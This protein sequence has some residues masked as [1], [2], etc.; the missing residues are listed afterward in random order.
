MAGDNIFVFNKSAVGVKQPEWYF[1]TSDNVNSV[2]ISD[3]GRYIGAGGMSSSGEAYLFYHAIPIPPALTSGGDDDD[4]DD[5]PF[6]IIQ[7]FTTPIGLIIIAISITGIVI[8]I[9]LIKKRS[10]S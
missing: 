4:D 7:F 9:I 8:V 6:D 3:D 5:K 10:K 1:N 2:S